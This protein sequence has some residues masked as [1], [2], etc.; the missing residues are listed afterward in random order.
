MLGASS[1][2]L[3]LSELSDV[4]EFEF[5]RLE[6]GTGAE[7]LLAATAG[8]TCV[9]AP[10]SLL[11][12]SELLELE[13]SLLEDEDELEE[14]DASSESLPEEDEPLLL[15]SAAFLATTAFGKFN[16][17]PSGAAASSYLRA[18]SS[19]SSKQPK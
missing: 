10:S 13:V 18:A 19:S 5:L 11:A 4:L 17:R 9:G 3:S 2:S 8:A 16:G 12:V 14:P 7:N 6:N 15:D 1:F